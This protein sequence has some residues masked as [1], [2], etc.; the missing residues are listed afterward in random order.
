MR[1]VVL[2]IVAGALLAGCN[3]SETFGGLIRDADRA[4]VDLKVTECGVDEVGVA[5]AMVSLTS[6][7]EYGTVLF[8]VDMMENNTVIGQG[9]TS[10]RNVQPGKTY[11]T[12]VVVSFTSQEPPAAPTCSVSLDFASNQ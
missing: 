8:N 1:R 11:Q 12:R 10:F 6:E 2:M 3:A 4:G 9:S 7:K 5:F